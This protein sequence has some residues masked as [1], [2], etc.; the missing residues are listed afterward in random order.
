MEG[1][2]YL[3]TFAFLLVAEPGRWRISAPH[4]RI[5]E[6]NPAVG[7][8][9]KYVK[10]VNWY[11]EST[12]LGFTSWPVERMAAI[13]LQRRRTDW[14]EVTGYAERSTVL[15][16]HLDNWRVASL[17]IRL[18]YGFAFY[19]SVDSAATNV[20]VEYFHFLWVRSSFEYRVRNFEIISVG[21]WGLEGT[22]DFLGIFLCVG[23][24]AIDRESVP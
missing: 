13:G 5:P 19:G 1:S 24:V 17:T 8:I 11:A 16:Y 6:K 3:C 2:G 23:L 18:R 12:L 22:S 9:W 14:P 4:K 21:L 20:V 7:I 10:I 15:H